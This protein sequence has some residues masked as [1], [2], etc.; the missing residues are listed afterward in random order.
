MED[1][2]TAGLAPAEIERRFEESAQ[3]LTTP[4]FDGD[5]VWRVWGEGEPLVLLHGGYGS[6]RHWIKTI[7]V[8]AK[9]RKLY[10]ADMPGLGDSASVPP[11]YDAYTIAQPI[12]EGLDI[13]LP[14]PARYDIAGFSFG[15]LIG[16]HVAELQ[17]DRVKRYIA[18]APGG[19]GI[20]RTGERRPLAKMARHM[21]DEER[22][23]AHTHNLSVIMFADDSN[24]DDL[25]I[26]LQMESTRRGRTKSPPIAQTDTLARALPKVKAQI[27]AIYGRLDDATG[28]GLAQREALFKSI[29]PGL[30]FRI[31][32]GG[33]HWVM[34][35][36]P[37]EFIA[38]L[39]EMLE[40]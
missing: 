20:E 27:K 22:R 25:A 38:I 32:E 34:Y 23:A 28:T 2:L 33:G 11:P 35:E 37:D 14:A 26:H 15:G 9:T 3:V 39:Q 16:G 13:L 40:E 31:I 36:T 7:P 8:M 5:L 6:W 24:I 10:V 4:C 29:Q 18:V 19:L 12:A 1:I 30:D 17:G 21:T